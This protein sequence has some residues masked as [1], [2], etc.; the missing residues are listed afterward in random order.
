MLIY[1]QFFLSFFLSFSFVPE[2][3]KEPFFLS[4]GPATYGRIAKKKRFS[5]VREKRILKKKS[6]LLREKRKVF[7]C[8]R[9]EKIF[10]VFAE[11]I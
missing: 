4:L 5:F 3:K 2:N 8:V 11:K 10:C 7:C 6:V 9:K 1:K